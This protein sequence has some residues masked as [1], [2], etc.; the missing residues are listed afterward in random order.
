MTKKFFYV[1]CG[2]LMLTIAYHLGASSA[3]AQSGEVQLGSIDYGSGNHY[4]VVVGRTLY[5]LS[6][7]STAEPSPSVPIPGS[8]PVIAV[9]GIGLGAMLANGDVYEYDGSSQA[10]LL[11][12]NM[13]G[14]S[15]FAPSATWG[16]VKSRYR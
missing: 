7:G 5:R 11:K 6:S 14:Q 4:S 12:G 15:T 1:C 9:N 10:W 3:T 2:L 8:S 13:L 16:Q